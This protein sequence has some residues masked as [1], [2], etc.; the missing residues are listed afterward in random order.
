MVESEGASRCPPE[1]GLLRRA[2]CGAR[3][4]SGLL[5]VIH[6]QQYHY[7]D[8]ARTLEHV[9][10]LRSE[11]SARPLIKHAFIAGML[12]FLPCVALPWSPRHLQSLGMAQM[13]TFGRDVQCAS[14]CCTGVLE[15]R[16]R[17]GGRPH[18]QKRRQQRHLR[19]RKQG[20]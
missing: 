2:V 9:A 11:R 6:R 3:Q 14:L 20:S 4:T 18:K 7:R 1:A 10:L 8:H 19:Q 16:G 5:C 15:H 12:H 17:N 13:S